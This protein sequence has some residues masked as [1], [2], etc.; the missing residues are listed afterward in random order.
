MASGLVFVVSLCTAV[1]VVQAYRRRGTD[2]DEVQQGSLIA[3]VIRTM[4]RS[5]LFVVTVLAA[6]ALAAPIE[7]V[8]DADILNFAL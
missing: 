7:A 3:Q 4:G 2:R 6:L 1:P 5:K 8:T